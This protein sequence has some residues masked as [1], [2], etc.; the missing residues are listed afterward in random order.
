MRGPVQ[1][2]GAR[3]LYMGNPHVNR[4]T[5]RQTQT[6]LP[7]R[8]LRVEAVKIIQWMIHNQIVFLVGEELPSGKTMC[9]GQ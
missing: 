5:D 3:V 4:Q 8:K 6:T 2:G 9:L 7:C 1:R